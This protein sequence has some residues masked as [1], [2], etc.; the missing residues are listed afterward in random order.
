MRNYNCNEYKS[1]GICGSFRKHYTEICTC[2]A[3]FEKNALYCTTPLISK[4]IDEN[5][6][7]VIFESDDTKNARELEKKHI[8]SLLKSDIVY[9]CNPGGYLGAS[10]MLELGYLLASNKEVIFM[11][12]PTE[13]IIV[14]ILMDN[15]SFSKM[16]ILSPKELAEYMKIS[17]EVSKMRDWFDNYHKIDSEFSL[18]KKRGYN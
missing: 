14:Q 8:E 13:P 9:I 17:N 11:E 12:K 7:F 1:I 5:A 6:E 15:G 2:I 18:T 3:E 16:N 4:I 10:V